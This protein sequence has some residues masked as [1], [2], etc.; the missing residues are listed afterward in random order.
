M[1]INS[2]NYTCQISVLVAGRDRPK[3][4]HCRRYCRNGPVWNTKTWT[5]FFIISVTEV[6]HE[7][8]D[9]FQSQGLK[10]QHHDNHFFEGFM[11]DKT[12]YKTLFICRLIFFCSREC[13]EKKFQLLSAPVCTV[14]LL[15]VTLLH[16]TL[17][18]F[19][20]RNAE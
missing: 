13:R 14:C 4:V 20:L 18:A 3:L 8:T 10:L 16:K 7:A 5:N 15:L 11:M 12:L 9:S 6:T 2:Q 19:F 17:S 1:T